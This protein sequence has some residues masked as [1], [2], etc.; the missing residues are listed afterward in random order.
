MQLRYGM[1]TCRGHPS[2]QLPKR[3]AAPLCITVRP[4]CLQGK[5]HRAAERGCFH[6]LQYGHLELCDSDSQVHAPN[7]KRPPS[8]GPC[9]D[10]PPRRERRALQRGAALSFQVRILL[11]YKLPWCTRTKRKQPPSLWQWSCPSM[12]QEHCHREGGCFAFGEGAVL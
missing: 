7:A 4:C 2:A 12:G 5:R 10:P 6:Y 11:S 9:A 3:K 1:M 8:A